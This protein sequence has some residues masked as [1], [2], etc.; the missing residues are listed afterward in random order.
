MEI[1]VDS[2]ISSNLIKEILQN[3]IKSS[4]CYLT[5][6]DNILRE[7]Y[8]SVPPHTNNTQNSITYYEYINESTIF[9]IYTYF[10]NNSK[11]ITEMQKDD[12][13]YVYSI[14][15][16]LS[17]KTFYFQISL[18]SDLFKYDGMLITNKIIWPS[19][20]K[21]THCIFILDCKSYI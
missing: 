5:L 7:N 13:V 15:V 3:N 16:Q 21:L 10:S 2:L 6:S 4:A 14:Q 9:D 8:C 11:E 17:L 20:S 12:V 19:D 1:I 18:Y